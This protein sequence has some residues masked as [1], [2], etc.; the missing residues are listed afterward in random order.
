MNAE[1]LFCPADKCLE[2]SNNWKPI[3]NLKDDEKIENFFNDGR[4]KLKKII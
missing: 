1:I 2:N 3:K 4:H